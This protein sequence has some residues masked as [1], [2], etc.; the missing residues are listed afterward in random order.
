MY[1]LEKAPFG[2]KIKF[3]GFMQ[4]D[5][6]REW[7][8]ES[9]VALAS[10]PKGFGVLVDETELKALPEDTKKVLQEG[11]ALY[12]ASGMSRSAVGLASALT[13]AQ[14]KAVAKDAG[15]Y[16]WERYIDASANPN[17]VA[18]AMAWIQDGVDPDAKPA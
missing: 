8:E 13:T 2:I 1:K 5:E 9:K 6:M 17:W 14:M 3:A 15:I 10:A 11:Q 16:E 18:V 4:P 12:K 7:L